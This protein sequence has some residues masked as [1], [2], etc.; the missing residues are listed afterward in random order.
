ML[1]I[2]PRAKIITIVEGSD[3][4]NWGVRRRVE[5][6]KSSVLSGVWRRM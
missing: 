2:N 3:L 5:S 4:D 1:P 6:A